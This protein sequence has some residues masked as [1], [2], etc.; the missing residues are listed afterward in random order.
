MLEDS[1]MSLENALLKETKISHS[2]ISDCFCEA[3]IYFLISELYIVSYTPFKLAL[4]RV[5]T[6]GTVSTP[7]HTGF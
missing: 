1:M 4:Y 3:E 6:R 5:Q 7:F 2:Q